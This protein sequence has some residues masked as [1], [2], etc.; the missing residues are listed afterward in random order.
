ME[1]RKGFENA[2]KDIEEEFNFLP[3]AGFQISGKNQ[4]GHRV[5]IGY[6]GPK[7]NISLDYAF[8]EET[9]Y[10]DLIDNEKGV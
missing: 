6:K 5:S 7:F 8:I 1:I 3:T 4:L 10:F 2:L 9:F